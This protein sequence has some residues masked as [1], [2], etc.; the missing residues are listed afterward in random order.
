MN[1]EDLKRFAAMTEQAQN[2]GEATRLQL[3]SNDATGQQ[4]YALG[5]TAACDALG[6]LILSPM[7]PEL[8]LG[9]ILTGGVLAAVA[10]TAISTYC[11]QLGQTEAARYQASINNFANTLNVAAS[12]AGLSAQQTSDVLNLTNVAETGNVPGVISLAQQYAGSWNLQGYVALP[13]GGSEFTTLADDGTD[14]SFFARWSPDFSLQSTA[15]TDTDGS[16]VSKTYNATTG[17]LAK[18]TDTNADGQVTDS[19][20][21]YA[22]GG[23]ASTLYSNDPSTSWSS[24]TDIKDGNGNVIGNATT[25]RDGTTDLVSID[26]SGKQVTSHLDASG[27]IV[28]QTVDPGIDYNNFVNAIADAL[29]TQLIQKVLTGNNIPA[30]IAAQSFAEAVIKSTIPVNGQTVDFSQALANSAFDIA[31]GLAGSAVG[32]DLAEALGLPPEAG[33]IIGGTTGN[34]LAQSVLKLALNDFKLPVGQS[35]LDPAELADG[36]AGAGGAAL[37]SLLASAFVSPTEA[38][39]VIG[40][41][42]T[43]GALAVLPEGDAAIAALVGLQPELAPLVIFAVAFGSDFIGSLIGSIFGNSHPSVGP[44]ADA[45]NIWDSTTGKFIVGAVGE[46]NGGSTDGVRAMGNALNTIM[47]NT[48]ATIGG[49][50]LGAPPTMSLWWFKGQYYYAFGNMIPDND[51]HVFNTPNAAIEAA[52]VRWTSSLTIAGGDPYMVYAAKHS[53]ATTLADFYKDLSSAHAYST[54][55]ADPAAFDAALALANDPA[56]FAQWQQELAQAQAMGL[57]KLTARELQ[58]LHQFGYVTI[59]NVIDHGPLVG[60]GSNFLAA[61]AQDYFVTDNTGALTVWEFNNRAG[62]LTD[63]LVITHPDGTPFSYVPGTKILGTGQ[64]LTG[65]GEYDVVAKDAGGAILITKVNPQGQVIQQLSLTNANGSAFN[66][67]NVAEFVGTANNLLGSGGWDLLS[68]DGQGHVTVN[69]F[70]PQGQAAQHLTLTYPT[71]APFNYVPQSIPDYGSSDYWQMWESLLSKLGYTGPFDGKGPEEWYTEQ[72]G[73]MLDGGSAVGMQQL[74]ARASLTG[75]HLLGA[76]G[77]PVNGGGYDL[78]AKESNGQASIDKFSAQGQL[79]SQQ[80]LTNADG[81]P[82]VLTS[83]QTLLGTGADF[84]GSGGLDLFIREAGGQLTVSEFGTNGHASFNQTMDAGFLLSASDTIAGTATNFSGHGGRDVFVRGASG[85]VTVWEFDS[86][87]YGIFGQTLEASYTLDPRLNIVGAGVNYTGNG[88]S[89][90]FL[91]YPGGQLAI[92]EFDS[93]G[94]LVFGQ[95]LDPS[96]TLL[97]NDTIIG[98]GQNFSG[99]GGHDVFVRGPSGNVTVWEFDAYGHGV[100]GQTLEASYT[101]DPRL[102]IVGA[103]M[104]YTGNGG[105]DLFLQYPGGQLAIHE[106]DSNGHLVFGQM[107]DPSFTLLADDTIIGAGQNFSGNSGRDVFVRGASGSITV[108][109]FDA[110]GHGVFGQTLEASYS[111]GAGLDIVGAGVNYTGSGGHDLFLRYA[112][113]QL[114]VHEFD[115]N[116]HLVFGQMLDPSFTLPANNTIIGAGQNF[117]GNGGRDVFVRGPSG[118]VTVWEF[119]ANGHGIYGQTLD[120]N[121]TLATSATIAGAGLNVFA[122]GGHDLF[123]RTLTGQIVIKEFDSAG[124]LTVDPALVN[125]DH[126]AFEIDA[127]S[128]IVGNVTGFKTANAPDLVVQKST[129]ELVVDE[130]NATSDTVTS[131]TALLQSNG[132]SMPLDIGLRVLGTG[133]NVLGQ[134]GYDLVI[135][136]TDGSK[137]ILEVNASNGH[138]LASTTFTG[139]LLFADDSTLSLNASNMPATLIGNGNTLNAADNIQA[140]FVGSDDTVTMGMNDTLAVLGGVSDTVNASGNT[141]NANNHVR[142]TV[143]GGGNAI[144]AADGDTITIEGNGQYGWGDAVAMSNGTVN[145]ADNAYATVAGSNNV[146]NAGQNDMVGID[147]T[148]GSNGNTV[149]F[150]DNG[151]VW[152]YNTSGDI[153]NGSGGVVRTYGDVNVTVNGGGNSITSDGGDTVTVAGNGQYGWG[154]GIAMF[155]GT[156]HLAD[157]A[158]ASVTGSNNA[159]T[160]GQNDMV[161]I[162][163]DNNTAAFGSGG[164]AHVDGGNGNVVNATGADITVAAGAANTS[165]IG[166]N[167][168][169][170]AG[171][172]DTLNVTGSGDTIIGSNLT[173]YLNAGDTNI[174]LQG[175]N[176]TIHIQNGVT[177]QIQGSNDPVI[178]DTVIS[179]HN[180]D[181]IANYDGISDLV[182]IS[183]L[184]FDSS[185]TATPVLNAAHTSGQLI[186]ADHGTTV[187][188]INL[189]STTNVGSFTARSDGAGGTLIVDPPVGGQGD[190]FQFNAA[191]FRAAAEGMAREGMRTVGIT[192]N[193]NFDFSALANQPGYH[194]LATPQDLF[195]GQAAPLTEYSAA[196]PDNHSA[197]PDLGGGLDPH[198]AFRPQDMHHMAAVTG[199]HHDLI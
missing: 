196:M 138:L 190:N 179:A 114:A 115:S 186:V 163:G 20:V 53:T 188:T 113:G 149:T 57:D 3:E 168:T 177:G 156:V 119:D 178:V 7:A 133:L 86:N 71:N 173:V 99:N 172:G 12:N 60:F 140:S 62:L 155:N 35:F 83:N 127:G 75:R 81:T 165:I 110:Y 69:E 187:A 93:N 193:G 15:L 64:N 38:G 46:D 169:I 42:A 77:D 176:D 25:N 30:T 29:A 61:N 67:S 135:E 144:S 18:E 195:H 85:N 167:S 174:T 11:T 16:T 164:N 166:N 45:I 94:H 10:T 107:L 136:N 116:G 191:G 26:S 157:N 21:F 68:L 51:P 4:K 56:Q 128:T 48:L 154:D 105:H 23:T 92:H 120:A 63:G 74:L 123:I 181:T 124:H 43:A 139:N 171:N 55:I 79:I 161:H 151:N 91:Q 194:D 66:Y 17:G 28:T 130:F 106:F 6:V 40:S 197:A 9:S 184:P 104:N 183:G 108:W 126:S 22:S 121:F 170:H 142:F 5:V 32:V 13:D 41:L 78:I 44:N 89:D 134:N 95:M 175:D 129:G 52:A 88:G 50:V 132:T 76:F 180:G 2:L 84:S 111:L 33:Q 102:N 147:G 90:L 34:L 49:T 96:F 103:G 27:T 19:E 118:N 24:K 141:I 80:L 150:G 192:E 58:M 153:V 117:S 70:N 146:I 158:N 14:A 82:Y 185:L 152:L 87:G 159:I 160:T 109:E 162:S 122:N 112:S 198:G 37:G 72:Y 73:V 131:S 31:G 125:P 182:D 148:N 47:G 8:T 36:L 100:Y 199:F 1:L 97:A 143:N 59:D 101:L 39:E 189:A 98:A 145:L 137:S 65:S 54:Y